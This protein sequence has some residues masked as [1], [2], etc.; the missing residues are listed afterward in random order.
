[1]IHQKL[2]APNLAEA[3]LRDHYSGRVV[4]GEGYEILAYSAGAAG[5]GI[6]PSQVHIALRPVPDVAIVL[7]LKSARA[8][9]EMV[10]LL[11]EYRRRVWP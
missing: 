8:V 3:N 5:A 9:D 4:A 2:P 7:R 10:G 11:L 1:M 6:P